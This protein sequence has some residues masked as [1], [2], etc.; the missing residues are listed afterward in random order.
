MT[1]LPGV[2]GEIEQT[3]GL[4]LTVKLLKARGGTVVKIPATARGTLLAGII[5]E[6]ATEKLIDE[7]GP[8][9]IDLPCGHMRGR[10][11]SRLQKKRRAIA[12][13][14][15]GKS[16]REVAL[17]CDIAVRTASQYRAELRDQGPPDQSQFLF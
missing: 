1:Q 15:D 2:A 3:I 16:L 10:D 6:Q 12:M 5:G 17:A 9:N 11:A 13:L 7:I 8:G 14:E 4:E